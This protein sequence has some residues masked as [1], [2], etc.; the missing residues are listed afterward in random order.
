MQVGDR[1]G[2]R[3]L[4]RRFARC[5][6]QEI[7]YRLELRA[8]GLTVQ[9]QVLEGGKQNIQRFYGL[10]GQRFVDQR[11][12][13]PLAGIRSKH[14][15]RRKHRDWGLIRQ[16]RS[17]GQKHRDILYR[18]RDESTS[19]SRLGYVAFAAVALMAEHPEVAQLVLTA[20]DAR[21]DMVHLQH[22]RL[23]R[24]AAEDTA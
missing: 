16:I 7:F 23:G 10:D 5:A 2:V 24:G 21:D 11:F 18:T 17:Q 4:L 6:V 22:R 1:A 12:V 15:G 8:L 20:M 3:D 14:H 19:F 13:N 9:S